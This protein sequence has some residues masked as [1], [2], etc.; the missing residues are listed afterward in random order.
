MRRN[1]FLDL[2]GA[3]AQNR[4]N[5]FCKNKTDNAHAQKLFFVIEWRVISEEKHTFFVKTKQI[6]SPIL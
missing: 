3:L 4:S 2:S 5:A 1:S 6:T